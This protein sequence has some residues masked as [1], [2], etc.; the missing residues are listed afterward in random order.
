MVRLAISVEG[1]T[2]ER[3]VKS[4]LNPH[5]QNLGIYANPI[6]LGQ[7]GGN[8][9]LLRIK[10][11]IQKL[12]HN[13]DHVTTFYDF[14]GFRDKALSDTKESLEH[15]ILYT[16]EEK[17]HSKLTPYVQMYEFEGI[18]FSDPLAIASCLQNE[19][20]QKWASDILIAHNNNPERINDSQITAP[21]KR[22]ESHTNYRKA[23]NGPDIAVKI[24]LSKLRSMCSGF[25][26]W[27]NK[28]ESL[29]S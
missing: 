24:G 23:V 6:L 11:D 26:K 21:S 12:I 4:V 10:K 8:V 9:Q 15:K 19:T 20:Y 29:T 18:L 22:L 5:F 28:I 1:L 16:V 25:D 13:F 27:V 2:E 7:N 17:F 3:L 14:Y